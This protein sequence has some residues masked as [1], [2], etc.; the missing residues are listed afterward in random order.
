MVRP[1]RLLVWLSFWSC[2]GIGNFI[3]SKFRNS[4]CET[5]R[6]EGHLDTHWGRA[7]FSGAYFL[8]FAMLYKHVL[9]PYW[10]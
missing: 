4:L 9:K 3:A 1:N 6:E 8:G 7:I 5:I 10:H 2:F